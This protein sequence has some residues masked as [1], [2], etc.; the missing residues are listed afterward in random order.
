MERGRLQIERRENH[1]T[2]VILDGHDISM[3][4]TRFVVEGIGP[5][6]PEAAIFVPGPLALDLP[7][8]VTIYIEKEPPSPDKGEISALVGACHGLRIQAV[9]TG[10]CALD[11]SWSKGSEM[12]EVSADAFREMLAAL[13]AI[14]A[15]YDD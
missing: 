1:T 4:V 7:A 8:E 9:A 5:G 15:D 10:R 12:V 3:V 13:A 6:I 2:G 14:G 11:G